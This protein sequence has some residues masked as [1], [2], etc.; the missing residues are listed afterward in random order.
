MKSIIFKLQALAILS[1]LFCTVASKHW[2]QNQCHVPI[3]LTLYNNTKLPD[4]FTFAGGGAKTSN[5]SQWD[6]RRKQ[7]GALLQKYELGHLP[8]KPASLTANITTSN[9]TYLGTNYTTNNLNIQVTDRNKT[10]SF[11]ASIIWPTTGEGP[12]PAVIAYAAPSI[13]IPSNIATINLDNDDI[14]Q[15]ND[16]SSRGIGK[17]YDLYGINATA[18]AMTA[19]AWAVS[20]II[21]ALES[22]PISEAKIN[23]TR[24]GMTGC[25]RNGKGA[26]VAGAFE[27]RIRL[28]IPQES[29][30]GGDACWRLSDAEQAAG[31]VVQ[32][33]SEI[34]NENVWFSTE[35]DNFA[36][37]KTDLLPFDHHMLAGMIAPRA[38]LAIE[39]TAYVWLSPQSSYGCMTA[40]R[41]V[42]DALGV[43][44]RMGFTQDGNHSHCAFSADQQPELTAFFDRFLLDAE[45]VNT[46]VFKT[47]NETFDEARWIDW[48]VPKLY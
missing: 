45:G 18:S 12:W 2:V 8:P 20:R 15:Q 32:T 46:T 5:A 30:S 22:L 21:D 23:T 6:C 14:A 17:F 11:S 7:I 26:L 42:W 25:S 16:A 1:S 35:F 33:S 39:N 48:T 13:P 47:T 44:D 37:Y 27:P 40:A 4:P 24:L 36:Q 9:A 43:S 10:I 28:T 3:N 34:V 41:K 31:Y 29:G 38:M 19:W